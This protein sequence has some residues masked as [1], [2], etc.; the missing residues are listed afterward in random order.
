M[1][2]T[3][4]IDK[5]LEVMAALR[6]PESGCPWDLQQ[7][8][9]TIVPSTIEECYELADAIERNDISHLEEELGDLLFQVVFYCR[10][11]E[12]LGH[13]DFNS[14]AK[15]LSEK[16]V[17]RHPHVFSDQADSEV[18]QASVS[19]NWEAIKQQ[20]RDAK[21][22]SGILDDIP[23]TLPS[24]M[25]AAKLQKRASRV[26]FDWDNSRAVIQ[27]LRSELDELESAIESG[28][29][30]HVGEEFGDLVFCCVNLS[31]HLAVD[32]DQQLRGA[33]RKFE[34]RFKY[35]ESALRDRGES[36]EDANLETMDAL[37]DEA[38]SRGL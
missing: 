6:D 33:N 28:D 34:S 38:K 22:Q 4:N 29:A 17:R 1:T 27:H 14:V 35:I 21:N 15:V 20:E 2:A 10:L 18:S 13:F 12:E 37:W 8:F 19:E 7:T 36:L 11:G 32:A 5:L 30:D 3:T 9:S 24:L 23:V 26:G 31:R 25:R 16:L